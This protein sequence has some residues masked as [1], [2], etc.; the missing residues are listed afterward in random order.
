M[1]KK[2]LL[3]VFLLAAL[4]AAAQVTT[5]SI[6]GRIVDDNGPVEGVTVVVIHQPSNT[7]YYTT[8]NARGWYQLSDV[9]PG[10]P[11]TVRI[12]YFSYKPLTVRE[13]YTYAGQY[14]VIDANLEA[15]TTDIHVGDQMTI[16][17][18]KTTYNGTPQINNGVYFSH[19]PAN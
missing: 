14:S 3:L 11:Y 6:G 8:T 15:G 12:H 1:I 4:P 19:T 7:Q 13:L 9:L 17:G 10:G 5:A 18:T 16:I 2:F